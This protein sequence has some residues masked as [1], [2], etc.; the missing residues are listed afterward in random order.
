M[1]I[2]G[3][4]KRNVRVCVSVWPEAISCFLDFLPLNRRLSL[5]PMP[6][7]VQR[8]DWHMAK[9]HGHDPAG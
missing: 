6:G 5:C 9:E 3:E 1:A 8:S 2:D 7:L 4:T